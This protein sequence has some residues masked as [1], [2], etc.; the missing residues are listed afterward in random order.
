MADNNSDYKK[1]NFNLNN[2]LPET[3]K[4]E[5]L[6]SL[7][8]NLFNRYL[9]KDE[10]DH[11]VGIIG[12]ADPNDSVTKQ[13]KERSTFRQDNQLQPVVSQKIGSVN[14]FMGFE[15]F[16]TRIGRTG[17]DTEK[18]DQWGN[19]LQFNWVPPIDFDKIINYRDYYWNSVADSSHSIPQYI[20]IKSQK[21]WS[22]ARYTQALK[23]IIDVVGV[24]NI[25]SFNM[26]A[27]KIILAGNVVSKYVVGNHLIV[28]QADGRQE[29]VTIE[30][31]T[32]NI[33]TTK[34]EIKTLE[35]FSLS[36]ATNLTVYITQVEIPVVSIS[37]DSVVLS[38]N[39]S[40]LL[41]D[42]YVVGVNTA[43]MRLYTVKSSTFEPITNRTTAV[44]DG[45]GVTG[46]TELSLYPA[47]SI[48]QAESA[49][50][51][52]S[53]VSYPTGAWNNNDIGKLLWYRN[54]ELLN[55][56]TG[57][58]TLGGSILTDTT[59]NF[60]AFNLQ[61][62][63]ILQIG[64][65]YKG[66]GK[67]TI[68]STTATTIQTDGGQF[69]TANN[70]SYR[71]IRPFSLEMITSIAPPISP[72]Q[73]QLW[74]NA[75]I[76][77]LSQW[78]GSAWTVVYRGIKELQALVKDRIILNY[79]NDND[80]SADNEWVHTSQITEF[81]GMIR[82]QMPII[83]YFPYLDMSETSYSEKIWRYRKD[84]TTSYLE[85][86]I[87]PKMVELMNFTYSGNE[88]SFPNLT[89]MR[90]NQKFGNFVGEMNVGDSIRLSG[91]TQNDGIYV[92]ASK[93]YYQ[94]AMGQRF[95]SELTFNTPIGSI[96]DLP[97]GATFGPA[98]T[99]VGDTFKAADKQWEFGG[100][101]DIRASSLAPTKNPM[102]D[103]NVGT[104]T[105]GAFEY[106]LGLNSQ[107][108]SSMMGNV[109]EPT[110]WFD[111][112]LHD[113]VL[114][115]DYQ[116]GDIRVYINGKRI[117]G[118]FEDL[119]SNINPDYVG[120]I[121]FVNGYTVYA[122]DIIR[123]ELGE[124]ALEDIGLRAIVVNT[125]IGDELYNLTNIRKIEQRKSESNQYPYF[126]LR[127]IYGN[128][129]DLSTSIFKY[130][131]SESSAV[132]ANV[133]KRIVTNGDG[134]DYTFVQE[135]RDADTG[136][137]Y[138][139]Y[140]YQEV[141]DELQTIWKHGTY[142]EQY[143]PIKIDNQW[144]MPNQW[145]Y[146]IGHE[147]YNQ[148]KLTEIFRHF[149][150]IID[151]QEQPG[152]FSK[153]A[154]LFF[155]DDQINYGIGGTI[156]EHNDGFDTL[157][158]ATFVNNGNPTTIIEF[159]KNQ[160]DNQI[161]Y[162]TERFY[163][164]AG[165]LF[166]D[167]SEALNVSELQ[168]AIT[169]ALINAIENNGKYD[170][171]FGD[172]TS[173]DT[174]T[175]TGVRNWIATLPQFNLQA[176]S[177]PFVVHDATLGIYE[178]HAHDGHVINVAFN[179]AMTEQ[180]VRRITANNPSINQ[181]V[182]SEAE[183]KPTTY[184][185]LPLVNGV[186]LIRTN[187]TAKTRKLYRS[188]SLS[189]WE[190]VDVN[191]VFAQSLLTVEQNL[192]AIGLQVKEA[193]PR[194]DF[195]DIELDSSFESLMEVQFNEYT[196]EE[197]ISTPL[198]N[199]DRFRQNNP[200]TWNYY[201]SPIQNDPLSGGVSYDTAGTWQALYENVFGTA[202]PHLEPWVLQGYENKPLW[203]DTQYA[204]TTGTR[205]WT[206]IM[207]N[208]IFDGI[209][210]VGRIAPNGSVGT[211]AFAQITNRYSYL[212]VNTG[213]V[214]TDDGYALDALLPPYWN[215]VNT[216]ESRVRGLYDPNAGE[217]VTTPQLNFEFG[218][219]GLVE[220][221]WRQSGSFMYDRL[222]VAYKI[223]PM[224]FM[225]QTFGVDYQIVACLQ[226]SKETEK[227]FS[228]SDTT[229][230]G[231]FI[232]ATNNI[233]KAYGLNQWYVHYQR[234]SGFDGISSEFRSL[235]KDWNT[236]LSYMVGAFIDTPSFAIES[237]YFD[238]TTK[239][240]EIV[241]KKTKGIADRWLTS[242]TATALAVPSPY[243][244]LRDRGIG[245]TVEIS[246]NC[247][248][249]RPIQYHPV[250]NYSVN[251]NT[252]S[253]P[254]RTFSYALKGIELVPARGTQTIEYNS[255]V[256][257]SSDTGLALNT[258][259]TF[260][261]RFNALDTETA[262]VNGNDAQTFEELF[263]ALQ[264]Q[265]SGG[266]FGIENGNVAV[267]SSVNAAYSSVEILSD[268]LFAS[269]IGYVQLN[270][271]T[272]TPNKFDGA[273]RIEGNFFTTFNDA[274]QIVINNS[275]LFNGTYDIDYVYYDASTYQ[276]LIFVK[277]QVTLPAMG[278]V[279]IDGTLEPV[280]AKTLPAEWVTGTEVYFNTTGYLPNNLDDEIP[281]Y[282]IR[283]SDR[284]F[285]VAE[286]KEAALKGVYITP[287]SAAMG[288][289]F[290]GKIL[291][292]F[293][294]LGG[295]L[296]TYNWRHH[297]VDYRY[298][299]SSSS[300]LMISGIQQVVD[301]LTGYD[302]YTQTLGFRY[303]N[304][305]GENYDTTTGMNNNW[306]TVTEKFINW[307]YALR[308]FQQESVLSYAVTGNASQD[309]LVMAN[310]TVPNWATG[311][312]VILL[313]D[314]NST[315][316]AE[317]NNPLSSIIPYYVI[318]VQGSTTE[319]KLAAT[320]YDA[321]RG[322]AIP[323]TDNG[324]GAFRVQVYKAIAQY[325]TYELN[326]F[327]YYA[328]IHHDQGI[329]S[330]VLDDDYTDPTSA[331]RLYDNNEL[332]LTVANVLVFREDKES[333]ISLTENLIEKNRIAE[334]SIGTTTH[335]AGMHLF[336]DGYEHMIRF[337]DYS[338]DNSLIYDS[339]LG[340]NTPRF[341][342]EFDRQQDFT[343]RPNVGGFYML[344]ESLVQ[345]FESTVN[346]LRYAYDSVK[347]SEG[348]TTTNL[349]RKSLGYDGPKDYMSDLKINPKT[350]FQ[351]WQ[352]MIQ[353]KGTNRAVRAFTNQSTFESAVVDE[354][355]AYKLAEFGDNKERNYIEMKLYPSDVVH[356][357]LRVE[358]IAPENTA[359]DSTFTGV[360]L[361]DMAR[362]WNQPDQIEDMRPYEAFFFNTKV[363]GIIENIAELVTRIDNR[364][365]Y[366]SPDYIDSVVM[367]Y[368]DPITN[369]TQTLNEGV[370][371]RF[372]NAKVIE[373]LVEPAELPVITTSILSYDYDAQNPAKIIDKDAGTV[374][375]TVPI[376]H[377]AIGQY[378]NVPYYTVDLRR[379]T[380][381]ATY[382]DSLDGGNTGN[383]T[384]KNNHVGTVWMDSSLEQ[385]VP[386]FDKAVYPNVN[387]RINKWG[388]LANWA[389]INLY[390]WTA[391]SVA[392]ED[393]DELAQRQSFDM[394]IPDA[395]KVTG[396]TYKL[397]YQNVN[398]DSDLD[399]NAA[400]FWIQV[401]DIHY[402]FIAGLSSQ[403]MDTTL[404]G[405]TC[406]VYKNGDFFE[407]LT[408]E[409]EQSVRA[410]FNQMNFGDYCHVIV[411][412]HVPSADEIQAGAYAY[413]TPRS[414]E[415]RFDA[416]SGTVYNLYY[417]WVK[418]KKNPISDV[419]TGVS[420]YS[421][422]KQLVDM[423]DPYMILQGVRTPDFG[424]G[425]IFGHVFD[426]FAF[427]LPYR[428]TQMIAKGLHG[429]VKDNNRTVMRFTRD[430]TLRDKLDNNEIVPKNRH[431]EWKLFREEQLEKIDRYLWNKVIEALIGFKLNITATAAT[432]EAIPSLNRIL[433]DRIYQADTQYGLG[434]EQV[435]TNKDL[436][437]ET[438]LAVLSD[439]NREFEYV[440][441]EEFLA[442][443][444]F[445][446]PEDI[447]AAMNEIY[448]NFSVAEVN[449]IFF[450]VLH[451]AM[452]LKMEHSEI[453]KTS[454]VALQISQNVVPAIAVP[455]DEL[456]LVPGPDCAAPPPS[457]SPTP[458]PTPT[459]AVSPTPT[460]TPLPVDTCG[461]GEDD[462]IDEE[463]DGRI[464][465][466]GECRIVEVE[467][468]CG[469]GEDDR[470]DED[471]EGRITQD[472]ECRIV[473]PTP[474]CGGGEFDRE[475]E[476]DIGRETEDNDCREIDDLATPT[477]NRI[478]G[479]VI[480]SERVDGGYYLE[481]NT[482]TD[483]CADVSPIESM[484]MIGDWATSMDYPPP[485]GNECPIDY[486]GL[487]DF[488][489]YSQAPSDDLNMVE[490]QPGVWRGWSTSPTGQ[491]DR[492]F[493]LQ[494]LVNG[495]VTV[496]LWIDIES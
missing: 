377:P 102:L 328:W 362:W 219:N 326:P 245:W 51:A 112:S 369:V 275:T 446:T 25:D 75:S 35:S 72:V 356:S 220:W 218:Q 472:G 451:D 232:D 257:M 129:L 149:K 378:Y 443:H 56:S 496:Y 270:S 424:Y 266:T 73:H 125:P 458:T 347:A 474:L 346:D 165:N 324:V 427:N 246:D 141:G 103:I 426:E 330:N 83:E 3:N 334:R 76:D 26:A 247:P 115:D 403:G 383:A 288:E 182:T 321:S 196:R 14:H 240:Y 173:F 44:L 462:R 273:F 486:A 66:Y 435:F 339:F 258:D 342:V 92:I 236:D 70:I 283:I 467:P 94:P 79:S 314:A 481:V 175:G 203:W 308:N 301:F 248:V 116:E 9:T 397:L 252:G 315:L 18:F 263:D 477:D 208:N 361:T 114:Y 101:R 224:R 17:V 296:T 186:Y 332:E 337:N 408:F 231:D 305:N 292:T 287:S 371:Y 205:Q 198:N 349:V 463:G 265:I 147:N 431:E 495:N 353:N 385:Y 132:N 98:V 157:V 187:T 45:L 13:I 7:N 5:F 422:K 336:F 100:I 466:D 414:V 237:D 8:K 261:V 419:N 158:S 366:I 338:V 253:N 24:T 455:Y 357:D 490:T 255:P 392:P 109:G 169:N 52:D 471:G 442:R 256:A 134:T 163:Q 209:I 235:W 91:F 363:S 192:Y 396:T 47:L 216:T 358:F 190:L 214:P 177:V 39:F 494:V 202:Y 234:Y 123:V 384:W 325:P 433:F 251:V 41:I 21:N 445:L 277:N 359:V 67:Y 345:N 160:Y 312:P 482:N 30:S 399:V 84:N 432:A 74:Y 150:S 295:Q 95:I 49:F 118:A 405:K 230:H 200:F 156:K 12:D 166:S 97:N 167:D 81:T 423:S 210:P 323:M 48:M 300:N 475:T 360:E 15:D 318:R 179:P 417:Y 250:Q 352:S 188:N 322:N 276:T 418:D 121:K 491:G 238:I 65:G 398:F 470:I 401:N 144:E 393:Y 122:S 375:A 406:E 133:L 69:F 23:T 229:F 259:Y 272:V 57:S 206:A 32:Y 291:M 193:T 221:Q 233:Y 82:A 488:Y 140:D 262:T 223:D 178:V 31:V 68:N 108:Y 437:R 217:F 317:F 489:D 469:T 409:S 11:I 460:P 271:P 450:A 364:I 249:A 492:K 311:T 370:E 85:T 54:T 119:A 480:I 106:V 413:Y 194:Y 176:L 374:I 348:R 53:D 64:L 286:T 341:Y 439:P 113:L 459:P 441:I 89:T 380:D 62:S 58:T 281:Y 120:G 436:S 146:N 142:S 430:F 88:F 19:A 293:T 428:Y 425:L 355:W 183:P 87:E 155:L 37:A 479:I 285:R 386:Y 382:T 135:L 137:L 493:V 78:T 440:N 333:R 316:P 226:I 93:K 379:P 128:R 410:Y 139:Y 365:V 181:I 174:A 297:A 400:P 42:G 38:G 96:T 228:H 264:T 212:P 20:V 46:F 90:F 302:A 454:W 99:S 151:L 290:I 415:K 22:S 416:K 4:G 452:S 28:S 391:S 343:L 279:T 180:I 185:G 6:D 389:D 457:P 27:Q 335:M 411:R 148:V 282:V 298:V 304:V 485:T 306:Q 110:F 138:C 394:T 280:N 1:T 243:A 10:F 412:A 161:R 131:E 197:G 145:Y 16:M 199:A 130:A 61:N 381:P 171:W 449:S 77:S 189:Q 319:F 80:W 29:L 268:T 152:L 468:A 340:L 434:D 153:T 484:L 260:E 241:V 456:R 86:S 154:G 59:K 284:E 402:D 33:A 390:Q 395:Q 111:N 289:V 127:D 483:W 207:W 387:D 329:L 40:N 310:G 143:V 373:F 225:H 473:E 117:Y 294:A 307:L 331:A 124:Y 244:K 351:F 421:A 448:L 213:S 55:G 278:N 313:D 303:R 204:D 242:L 487:E 168:T 320:A 429:T 34:T 254:F 444:D 404:A 344:G 367:T 388:K 195:T 476:D 43:P 71:V 211:G 407:A 420:L 368:F 478:E 222:I 107:T 164:D 447:I 227:V 461:E 105:F 159:A 184:N 376:W 354:F 136:R 267:Y 269:T 2:F 438:I 162:L 453:F 36:T 172:T 63:D 465:Q 60:N 50:T 350:Q 104:G 327:K 191:A 309:S 464:T 274:G 201:H 215:S 126:A 299:D 372:L 239:D 170:Q